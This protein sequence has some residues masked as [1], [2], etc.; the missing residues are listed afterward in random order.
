MYNS[1]IAI[2]VPN[3]GPVEGRHVHPSTL[4]AQKEIQIEYS[5]IFQCSGVMPGS[6]Q[7]IA[8]ASERAETYA[9]LAATQ[10]VD[11]TAEDVPSI[12]KSELLK[13]V[14]PPPSATPCN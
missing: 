13:L 14:L 8:D 1:G 10:K 2:H 5:K 9:E 3:W 7:F 11:L 6:G 4:G 12:P